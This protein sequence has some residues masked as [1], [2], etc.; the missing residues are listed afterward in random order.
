MLAGPDPSFSLRGGTGVAVPSR[1]PFGDRV[2]AWRDGGVDTSGKRTTRRPG[3]VKVAP[4]KPENKPPRPL[5]FGPGRLESGALGRVGIGGQ[6]PGSWLL[7]RGELRRSDRR[8]YLF[9]ARDETRTGYLSWVGGARCCGIR[10]DVV[11]AHP[12]GVVTGV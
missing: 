5:E 9:P 7:R 3:I 6:S 11:P 12:K 2:T 4:A 1:S 8:T 10:R